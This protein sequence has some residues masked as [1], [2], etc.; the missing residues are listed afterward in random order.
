MFSAKFTSWAMENKDVSS[1]N[2]FGQEVKLSD[3]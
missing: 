2:S 3:K 1:A